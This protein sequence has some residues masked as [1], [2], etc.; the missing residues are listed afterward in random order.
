M[1]IVVPPTVFN[2]CI[3]S[4]SY[5]FAAEGFPIK[6]KMLLIRTEN[7]TEHLEVTVHS[8]KNPYMETSCS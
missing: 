8:Y 1:A 4:I 7:K 3:V 5:M 2:E 6:K